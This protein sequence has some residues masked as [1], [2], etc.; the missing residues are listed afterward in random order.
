MVVSFGLVQENADTK[1]KQILFF[2]EI[3]EIC[4]HIL[5]SVKNIY[6]PTRMELWK[7][8]AKRKNLGPRRD[9]NI[10]KIATL[11]RTATV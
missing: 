11:V 3:K 9:L 2:M 10:Y 6:G 7:S 5:W 4:L 1:V 8:M